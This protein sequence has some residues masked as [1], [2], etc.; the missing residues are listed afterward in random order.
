MKRFLMLVVSLTVAVMIVVACAPKVEQKP[1]QVVPKAP[2]KVEFLGSP[3]GTA[4]YNLTFAFAEIL[5]KYGSGIQASAMETSGH[6]ENLKTLAEMMDKR[7]NTL[8]YM[9]PITFH[10]GRVGDPPLTAPYTSLKAV[11]S[12]GGMVAVFVTLDE[13][14]KTKD[15]MIGKRVAIGPKG[16]SIYLFPKAIL[17]HGWGIWDKIKVDYLHWDK[18]KD[19]LLDGLIDV[20]MQSTS[21]MEPN[22]PLTPAF[23]ALI[24]SK[25]VYYISSDEEAIRLAKE[26][27]G[28]PYSGYTVPAGTFGPTQPQPI[29]GGVYC[30]GWF[31]DAAMDEN[32]VYEIVKAAYENIGKFGDYDASGKQM[33]REKMTFFP[34]LE[35]KDFH[36]GAVRFYKEKGIKMKW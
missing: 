17:E 12:A 36:P 3:I 18:N 10:Q 32:V 28:Y 29:V 13:K 15:D 22:W 30:N 35:E 8:I 20:G 21:G 14:I 11:V 27:T 33:T 31:T 2:A 24:A 4:G 7:K 25:K 19:A 26:K 5:N 34:P 9:A 6:A 1:E 16:T 23:E